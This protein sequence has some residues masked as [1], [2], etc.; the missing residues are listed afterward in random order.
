MKKIK[1][2]AWFKGN[3]PFYENYELESWDLP[4]MIYNVQN[5]YDGK[6]VSENYVLGGYGSFGSILENNDNFI[7][8]QYTGLKDK[9]GKEIYEHD[10]IRYT[11]FN[12][13]QKQYQN[14]VVKVPNILES[15]HWFAEL[16]LMLEEKNKCDIEIIGNIYENF[17]LL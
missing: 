3:K 5:L 2:R 4:Q 17:E 16:E 10:I 8:M 13:K 14:I 7:L 6:G 15:F 9:N 12:N 1:F 11:P